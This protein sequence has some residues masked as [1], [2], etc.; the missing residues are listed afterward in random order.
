MTQTPS[1][2]VQ[3]VVDVLKDGGYILGPSQLTI[4]TVPFEFA[5]TATGGERTLEL[6][7]I[8]DTVLA[9]ERRLQQQIMGVA[10]ALDLVRSKR[11][12][13]VVLVGPPP[14]EPT[15]EALGRVCRVLTVGTPIGDG[16]ERS[17]R[18]A[19]A[20]LLPLLL[21]EP[22]DGSSE[23]LSEVEHR[24]RR[25][26]ESELLLPLVAASPH[27]QQAVENELKSLFVTSLRLAEN[28]HDAG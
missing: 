25:D 10:R 11:S 20:V 4:G 6:V 19:L 26:P 12:L 16:A 22:T 14:R 3:R 5:A 2:P 21:P 18:D 13:T 7:V 28:Q 1:Q 17:V 15:M 9:G 8:V 27:G 23:P 24:I